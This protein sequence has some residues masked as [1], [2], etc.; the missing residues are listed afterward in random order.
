MNGAMIRKSLGTLV[1]LAVITSSNSFILT[2]S[3]PSSAAAK[4]AAHTTPTLLNMSQKKRSSGTNPFSSMLGDLASSI[5]SSSNNKISNSDELNA[6]LEKLSPLSW[7]EIRSQWEQSCATEEER[8]FRQ[9]VQQGLVASPLNQ[10]RLFHENQKE[11]DIRVTFYRDSA[12]WCP[13]CQKVWFALEE[14]Q[15]PYRVEKINMSCYGD[16]PRDFLTRIQPNGQIPVCI[17]D[18]QMYG[19]SNDI[20]AGLEGLFPEHKSLQPKEQ[21]T[22]ARSY[23]RLEQALAGAWLGWLRS[24]NNAGAKRQFERTIDAVEQALNDI[25]GPF[26][27]G[28]EVSLV[29]VQFL[30][31]LER[32][33]ASL[34][35]FKGFE[36][37]TAPGSK[38]NKFP[39]INRWFD[40]LEEK[41]SYQLTKSDYY[42]HA[43]DLPPQLGGCGEEP[44][45]EPYRIKI[46]G[47]DGTS[48]HL[49]LE[50]HNG[51][52]EPDWNFCGSSFTDHKRE[53]VERLSQNHQ[54]IVSFAS[55][56]A[57]K[58]GM[59]PV[60]A[61]LADPNATP[62]TAVQV[63]VNVVLQIVALALLGD[64]SSELEDKLQQVAKI[65]DKTYT[66]QGLIPSLQYLR[67]RIGVPRDM[68]YPAARQ[69]RAHLNWAIDTL[70]K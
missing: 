12:S 1:P 63:G 13:Y 45:G 24:N 28:S 67:D 48:W 29:D 40:A 9:L 44:D 66:Q 16:K 39:A 36:I 60:M 35:Y 64:I 25:E 5:I 38:T 23:L 21:E 57:G 65:S 3:T 47:G 37:R 30:S 55:R 70:E 6:K 8:N 56:G 18:G 27:M 26:F 62:N 4:K 17:I 69:L 58:K 14:K 49:P 68:R 20:L 33:C 50:P 46:N 51:G 53:A 15:I 31:F 42:T 11:E 7:E 22:Q 32:M 43:W 61:A 2:H 54:G 59:P 19:Q 52:I 10:I 34:L 41:L